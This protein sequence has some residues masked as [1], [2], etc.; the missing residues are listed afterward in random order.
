MKNMTEKR[1]KHEETCGYPRSFKAFMVQGQPFQSCQ[2]LGATDFAFAAVTSEGGVVAWGDADFGGDCRAVAD[3]LVDV[4]AIQST[5]AAFAALTA[6]GTVVAWGHPVLGGDVGGV[7]H[8]LGGVRALQ[9][10]R[11]AFCAITEGSVVV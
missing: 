3:H 5:G 11:G 7:G 2:E 10:S 4:V 9:S 8:R 1:L 6:Q